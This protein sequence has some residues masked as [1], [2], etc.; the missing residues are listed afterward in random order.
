[1]ERFDL[2]VIGAGSAGEAAAHYGRRGDASVAIIDR[3]LFGGSCP[4]FACMPSKALLHAAAAHHAGSDEWPWKRASDFRDYMISR[5][6]TDHPDDSGHVSEL[7][8]AGATVVRGSASL[9]GPGRVHVEDG[10]LA[11]ER[12][13]VL[14]ANS[15]NNL[16]N[17]V[18]IEELPVQHNRILLHSCQSPERRRAPR[19]NL[20]QQCALRLH[21][22][23][24]RRIMNCENQLASLIILT[25]LHRKRP[26][27]RRG[28]TTIQRQLDRIHRRK[29]KPM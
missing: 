2:V 22:S 19:T 29:P 7:R 13:R 17:A 10:K 3:G 25:H 4:F 24:R 8:K 27:C 16:L 15:A 6:D 28:E 18:H 23:R 14:A 21:C 12:K 26:L 20:A 9:R 11:A 1:M 5:E